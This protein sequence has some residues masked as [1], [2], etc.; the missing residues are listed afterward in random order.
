ML[1]LLSSLTTA[2]AANVLI[3][4]DGDEDVAEFA[5]AMTLSG[6]DVTRSSEL[7]IYEWNFTGA[8]VDLSPADVIVWFD[9]NTAG[10]YSMPV[11]GQ[12]ALLEFVGAGGGVL[13]FGQ[14]GYNYL[15]G[16][17]NSLAPLIPLRSWTYYDEGTISCE[18]DHPVCDGYEP[19][20]TVDLGGGASVGSTPAVG[21][22]VAGYKPWWETGDEYWY[23]GAAQTEHERGR[24]VQWAM[25]GN[26]A[27]PWYQT[28]WWDTDLA[29]LMHNSIQW[30]SQGPPIANAGGPYS[31]RAG[32]TFV[33]DGSGSRARGD[34]T[35]EAYRWDFGSLAS[36]ES[37]T[38]GTEFDSSV[39]DGPITLTVTLEVE[40]D[41]GQTTEASTTL[42]ADNADP[43]VSEM[44]CPETLDEGEFG[45]FSATVVDPEIDDTWTVQWKVGPMPAVEGD[46]VSMF[47]GDNGAYEI[48][49][50]VT[51]DDGGTAEAD[52]PV[53]VEILNVPPTVL[54]SPTETVDALSTY[55][56]GP[57]VDDP[58]I[59]DTHTWSLEGPLEAF[60]DPV[61]GELEWTPSLDD[62][63]AHTFTLTA[64]DGDDD[65]SLTWE[66][67]V[68]WPDVDGDGFRYD[69]DCDDDDETIYPEAE[70]ACDAIDGDCDGS[71]VDEFDDLDADDAPDCIDPD[72]DGD[73][74]PAPS[75]C[76]DLD[77]AI[78]PGAVEDCDFSDSDCDGSLI[79]GFADGDEDGIPDCVDSDVDG[80]GM[81]DA[82]EEAFG[83][84]P[85]DPSDADSDEDG[86]GRTALH[87][88]STGSDPTV[89]EGPGAPSVFS[90]ED[91]T[92]INELPAVLTV[93]DG[94]A[95][96]AQELTHSFTVGT[97]ETMEVPLE[98][99]EDISGSGDGTT[100]ATITI[101]LTENSWVYWTAKAQDEFTMGPH[102]PVAQFFVNLINDPPEA[103]GL[104]SPMDGSSSDTV[105]LVAIVPTDPDLDD[106]YITFSLALADGSF[107]I[108]DERLGSEETVRWLPPIVPVEGDE[109]CWNAVAIDEHGLSGPESETACFTIDLTNLAPTPPLLEA[110]A[111][112]GTVESLTPTIR[113]VNGE[114][115]EGRPTQHR[116]ELDTDP[117]FSSDQLQMATVDTDSTGVTTWTPDES[118]EEDAFVY[119]RVLCSDGT[120]NSEW[121]NGAFLLSATNNPP[122][123]PVLL[124]PS[125][126]VSFGEDMML[127]T[128]N[129][130]DPEGSAVVHDFQ[131]RDLRDAVMAEAIGIEQGEENTQWSP[132]P[133]D[134]G[135]YQW[136]SRA[137]DDEGTESEWAESRSFVVGTPDLIEEPELGGMVTGPKAEGCSCATQRSPR[138]ALV[139][140]FLAAAAVAQRRKRPRC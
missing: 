96:L 43:V 84:D 13:L 138:G 116:F 18:S 130:T 66:V 82:W 79:D 28:P 100:S 90:P 38:A 2:L 23:I 36:L 33:M 135:Y 56:F 126:G 109:L 65:G 69:V 41:S 60:V 120:N 62:V 125:E 107:L 31:G 63:G 11:A 87:E 26:S 37:G 74:V 15:V 55:R 104:D 133:L 93:V 27:S 137:L 45:P 64:N 20:D 47:F 61:T 7:D 89:Y 91:A 16:R 54:G 129:S 106:V 3:I 51:D 21:E 71:L 99:L 57:G 42:F 127:V 132:G 118:Y 121:T 98:W 8:T 59:V 115:P 97:T 92:E 72:A 101:P 10:S 81:A 131:V 52:C 80:D 48:S 83:L 58:G 111:D 5:T 68:L 88:F 6:H 105:E 73:G 53:V 75:D 95:P 122:N 1:L 108:S 94:D 112:G 25:W 113:V 128:T 39:L 4:D 9:G 19:E 76:D 110:P 12:E 49:V 29:G 14:N 34:A 134:E 86:D 78:F 123:V 35:L 103:P 70:E 46:S 44:N 77:D 24:S 140:L 139:W 124:D 136:T 40:D 17:H 102:M 22:R 50:V 117:T 119:L 114:D 67:E 32:D 85:E 30:L